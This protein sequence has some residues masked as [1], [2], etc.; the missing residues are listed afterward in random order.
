MTAMTAVSLVPVFFGL[1]LGY[2]AG[3]R[4]IVDQKN[5]AGLNTFLLSYAVPAALFLAAA[6]TPRQ[7]L[8]SHGKLFLVLTISM[9][10]VFLVTLVVEVKL[11]RFSPADS[12]ALLLAVSAPNWV[13][14]GFPVFIGL[15]GPQSTIPVA[16][17][18]LCGNLV[19]VPLTLLL[20]E[21]GDGK[22][23]RAGILRRYVAAW[24]RCLKKA[25]VLA[26]IFGI[27]FSLA[28][29]AVPPVG[30]RSLAFFADTV[31][32]I[33][34]FVTGVVLS[35]ESLSIDLNVMGGLLL[36]LMIQPLLAFAV[37]GLLLHYPGQIVRDAVLLMACPSGF[38][39]VLFAVAYN[40]R[41]REAASVLLLSSA[42]SALTL[43]L[44]IPLLAFIR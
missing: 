26:P 15:Y 19:I 18:V 5:V 31:A 39:G 21:A 42:G 25:I 28:G 29:Y 38:F 7:A 35:R 32:G 1:A 10:S 9:V 43:S 2:L 24:W 6:Q 4:G 44:V 12:A 37:A 14:V 20:L 8:V 3:R 11:C 34:L 36:K 30:I 13:A 17:A 16:V 27:C 33:S 23:D 41:T 22:G 40:A